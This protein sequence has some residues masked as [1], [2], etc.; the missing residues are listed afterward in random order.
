MLTANYLI[1]KELPVGHI[2]TSEDKKFLLEENKN[3]NF[4]YLCLMRE[5]FQYR[6]I[7]VGNL[8]SG[9]GGIKLVK[10]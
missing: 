5:M 4:S 8:L 1:E 9:W 2:L 10:L 3:G 6:H 7:T